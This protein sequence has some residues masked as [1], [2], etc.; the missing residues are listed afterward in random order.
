[1]CI[2][3]SLKW[4]PTRNSCFSQDGLATSSQSTGN[5]DHH[6][7]YP[8]F[9]FLVIFGF[10]L[11]M[12]HSVLDSYGTAN[13]FSIFDKGGVFF[14][15]TI[16]QLLISV[17]H[18]TVGFDL[19]IHPYVSHLNATWSCW[20]RNQVQCKFFTS[21]EFFEKR[22]LSLSSIR[23]DTPHNRCRMLDRFLLVFTNKNVHCA[24]SAR[25][26]HDN[27]IFQF[28]LFHCINHICAISLGQTC[29]LSHSQARIGHSILH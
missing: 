10:Q 19:V 29:V 24:H 25:S 6:W 2:Y 27:R 18:G 13:S 9:G 8:F 14:F 5:L 11:T 20:T 4:M 23:A 22:I 12:S 28:Q 16:N 15:V 17:H 26:L 3:Q 7:I 1:M 21:E